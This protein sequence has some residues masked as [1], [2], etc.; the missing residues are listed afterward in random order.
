MAVGRQ[1]IDGRIDALFGDLAFQIDEGVEVLEGVG[2]GRVGRVVGRHVHGLHRCDGPLGR[3]GD[4]LL[5]LAHFRGQRRLITDG[6]G[7]TAQESRHFRAGLREAEDVVDEQQRVGPGR[8]AEPFAHR[9]RRQGHA[10]TGAR[11]FV[12]LAE[13]HGRLR[14]DR[15]VGLADL[16][17][18]HF[19]PEIV[20]LA[21][22]LAD[23]GKHRVAAV[24]AGD[25]GDQFGE[26][27]RLAEAGAAEQAGLAAA[28]QRRQ[29]VDD[30]DARLEQ[31]RLGGQLD[32]RAAA[33]RGSSGIPRRRPGRGRRSVRRA[34]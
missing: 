32:R 21:R 9:Q 31:F 5:Q 11:R 4:A 8:V 33:R 18:L 23:A 20:A 3:A 22:P 34:G 25:A 30:L 6:A 17:F 7:H 1:R 24:L 2:R 29:Q 26:N 27:D 14:D 15:A 19:E 16:G 10:Q 12:H 13:H 28:N